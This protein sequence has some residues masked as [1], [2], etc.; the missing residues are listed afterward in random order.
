[1]RALCFSSDGLAR[2]PSK[3]EKTIL[4]WPPNAVKSRR[5]IRS[6]L[7]SFCSQFYLCSSAFTRKAFSQHSSLQKLSSAAKYSDRIMI[8]AVLQVNFARIRNV[9]DWFV[10][11]QKNS[12]QTAIPHHQAADDR[13]LNARS[14]GFS[15]LRTAYLRSSLF[16]RR[17]FSN[18]QSRRLKP[19]ATARKHKD[20]TRSNRQKM[21]GCTLTRSAAFPIIAGFTLHGE[22]R[23]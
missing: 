20:A 18:R 21:H 22:P 17:S 16:I 15:F 3:R 9:L 1:M 13:P 5:A 8:V 14:P 11:A 19:R 10:N 23:V 2:I 12:A 6:P 4:V 7:V